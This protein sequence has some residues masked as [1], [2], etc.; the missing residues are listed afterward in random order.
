MSILKDETISKN[1]YIRFLLFFSPMK[2]HALYSL[3]S[4]YKRFQNISYS[5][6][7]IQN[8]FIWGNELLSDCYNQ[9]LI[10]TNVH[11]S[12]SF[13]N[14]P[15]IIFTSLNEHTYNSWQ[16]YSK[17]VVVAS[18]FSYYRS[19]E[20]NNSRIFVPV[21]HQ[22]WK[23]EQKRFEWK[24]ANNDAAASDVGRER[25]VWRDNPLIRPFRY[26][27]YPIHGEIMQPGI[28]LVWINFVSR[29]VNTHAP[30]APGSG[31]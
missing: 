18:Y 5:I 29:H 2:I 30:S 24:K 4:H 10:I 19:L 3:Y 13:S 20:N 1:L 16:Q 7:H 23:R 9:N 27:V 28:G 12:R 14:Q 22:R 6:P 15:T 8:I 21:L 11:S 25:N 17:K 31:I 26:R